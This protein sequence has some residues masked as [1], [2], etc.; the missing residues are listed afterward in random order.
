M[1][2]VEPCWYVYVDWTLENVPRP[3]YVGKGNFNRVANLRRSQHHTNIS[4]KYGIKR[5]IAAITS[6]EDEAF[7][8]EGELIK[9]YGTYVDDIHYNGIGCNKTLGG[10]GKCPSNETRSKLRSSALLRWNNAEFRLRSRL[11]MSGKKHYAGPRPKQSIAISGLNNP[12]YGKP[13]SDE[14]KAKI[15]ASKRGTVSP[16]KGVPNTKL[17][18]LI[19]V[20]HNKSEIMFESFKDA[21]T[22]VSQ[23]TEL[24]TG[25]I[26]TL[27]TR[28]IKMF[29]GFEFEYDFVRVN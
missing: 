13:L 6:N 11:A 14:V 19:C 8:L 9:R 1:S 12:N 7:L 10:E 18:K 23:E 29:Q 20:I 2:D 28:R 3:F 17:M 22:Y 21:A 16:F 4:N 25:Y 5:T 24:S 27:F 15:A 26:K